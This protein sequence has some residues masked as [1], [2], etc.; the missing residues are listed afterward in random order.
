MGV[1]EANAMM[2]GPLGQLADSNS[3]LRAIAFHLLL[4]NAQPVTREQLAEASG[5]DLERTTTMLEELDRA[6]RIRRDL[7]GRVV[8]S[9]GL[10]VMPDR[11]Q[12]ELNVRTVWTCCAY[13]S[14]VSFGACRADGDA[15][16]PSPPDLILLLL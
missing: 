10:S 12:I 13:D 2:S 7:T 15:L 11:H 5:I 8:G 6:G 1:G 14:L 9:A 4:V 16:T 3:L